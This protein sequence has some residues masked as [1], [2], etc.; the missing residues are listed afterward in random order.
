VIIASWLLVSRA[1]DSV[2]VTPRNVTGRRIDAPA[3]AATY[4]TAQLASTPAAPGLIAGNMRNNV[5]REK[6][7]AV[8]GWAVYQNERLAADD[9]P[10]SKSVLAR[11]SS[12]S[13]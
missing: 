9:M 7:F 2:T 4:A 10:L 8:A 5:D 11:S 3:S 13:S 6:R 1:S 12:M